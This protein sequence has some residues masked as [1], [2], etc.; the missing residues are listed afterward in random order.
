MMLG[1]P[2]PGSFRFNIRFAVQAVQLSLPGTS[3]ID[4]PPTTE[5]VVSRFG[6]ILDAATRPD[7]PELTDFVPDDGYRSVFL[8]LVRNL[9]PA[10]RDVDRVEIRRL[11]QGSASTVLTRDLISSINR[12]LA[13]KRPPSE[14]ERVETGY[15]RALHLNEDWIGVGPKEGTLRRLSTPPDIVEDTLTGLIDKL[16]RVTLARGRGKAWIVR[17]ISEAGQGSGA[18]EKSSQ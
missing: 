4:S 17:D 1:T 2:V 10:G 7:T 18:S 14:D 16:V 15:L 12:Y 5:R 8:K 6:E 13:A 9:A 11:D 3:L